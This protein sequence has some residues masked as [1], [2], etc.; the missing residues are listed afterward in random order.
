MLE[1]NVA[2]PSKPRI[3]NEEE[4]RGIYEIDGLYPGTLVGFEVIGQSEILESI[5]SQTAY[6]AEH[7]YSIWSHADKVLGFGCIVWGVNTARIPSQTD[8]K[9]YITKS[10]LALKEDSAEIVYA[11]TQEHRIP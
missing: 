1:T 11:M 6:E 5:N 10:H 3:V 2:L 8:E 4:F 9:S 7:R